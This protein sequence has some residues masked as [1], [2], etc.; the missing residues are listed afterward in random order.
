MGKHKADG[1]NRLWLLFLNRVC[2]YLCVFP[3]DGPSFCNKGEQNRKIF[4]RDLD[5]SCGRFQYCWSELISSIRVAIGFLS[6]FLN[7]L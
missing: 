7:H 5:V 4:R 2:Q 6:K 1:I 3:G